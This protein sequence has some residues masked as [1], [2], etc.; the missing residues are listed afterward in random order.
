MGL[1]K[2]AKTLNRKQIEL[3]YVYLGT[4]RNSIR[5]QTIFLLSVKAGLR[6]KEIAGITWSMVADADG[7]IADFIKLT[8]VAS[9]GN[10]GRIIPINRQ[11]KS[12]L[13]ELNDLERN[14]YHYNISSRVIQTER[15]I[16][17]SPQVIVNLFK[18][19]YSDL[20]LIGCS[21][22]SGRRTFVTNAAKRISTVGGSLRDVQY[23]A[24]HSSLQTTQRYIEGDS[25]AQSKIVDL[26]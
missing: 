25:A 9:K 7:K 4:T 17:T 21:S 19:W 16:A 26:I 10:S 3:V 11:L 22:H 13:I 14:R 18:G 6:A 24:G 12:K 2:Q 5:N 15:A 8:N 1:Q 23:L 20:G